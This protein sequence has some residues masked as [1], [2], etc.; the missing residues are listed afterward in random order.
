MQL[1]FF[2]HRRLTSLFAQCLS[3]LLVL[4]LA[5]PLQAHSHLQRN[6]LGITVAVCTLQ[7]LQA[8]SLDPAAGDAPARS[9]AMAFSDLINDT[10]P[11]VAALSPPSLQLASAV[12]VDSPAPQVPY[13]TAIFGSIRAPPPA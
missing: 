1:Q 10:S 12:I 9:A 3:A 11:M 7:G 8:V 6:D 5:L 2:R 13:R 4:Q